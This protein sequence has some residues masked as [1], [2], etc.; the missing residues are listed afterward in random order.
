MNLEER[1][2]Q[3]EQYLR[4]FDNPHTPSAKIRSKEQTKHEDQ[5]R[6]PGKPIGSKGGGIAMP[7]PD[8]Q[9]KVT[10]ESCPTCGETLGKAYTSYHFTQM[11]IPEPTC[12]T[13]RYEVF[14]YTCP[15]CKKIVDAGEHLPQGFYGKN[16]SALLGYLKKEGLSCAA[17]SNYF[18][19]VYR[20]PL[21]PV[22]VFNKLNLLADSLTL[23][24]EAIMNE[25]NKSSF[26]H[27]DET[28]LRQDGKNGFVWNASTPTHCLFEYDPSRASE[29]AKR[30]LANFHGAIITDDYKG[31][32]WHPAR[33]LCWA[34]L[35][36]EAKE[37]N[38]YDGAETQY[39]RLKCLYDKAKR[40]QQQNDTSQFEKLAWELQDI[41]YCYHV[42]DGCKI[43][44]GKLHERSH[45]WL[46]GVKY[47][48][49]PLTN[50][51]GERCLRKIVLQ[52][53]R[54][55][56]IRNKKGEKFINTFLTCVTTWKLQGKNVY[57]KLL[58]FAS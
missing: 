6:F 20:M 58:D 53:N 26:V 47:P 14:L 49:I 51:H 38:P 43:M 50:N 54:I 8:K 48:E 19:D 46:R 10:K 3:L 37:F 1:I 17:I 29:V 45:L 22:A 57:S 28:G 52:R 15:C 4:A 30:I 16:T 5:N 12:I 39:R 23:E 35:I 44:H 36:R 40:A 18:V 13:T 33:Q 11:D 2:A 27:M 9:E 25:I 42:L 41:A 7:P 55:G 34:H 24:K 31:Y 32:L 21:S 56:C